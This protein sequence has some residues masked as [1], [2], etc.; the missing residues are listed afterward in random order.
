MPSLNVSIDGGWTDI[1]ALMKSGKLIDLTGNDVAAIE[2]A[3]VGGGMKSGAT[4][5]LIRIA[6]P[7]GRVVVT[8]TS[9]MLFGM[10][11]DAMR[12]AYENPVGAS[13][14]N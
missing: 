9:L 8:E 2:V 1:P 12:A 6:L 4:S 7:D 13:D 14:V 10:A 11:A 3:S 5:V